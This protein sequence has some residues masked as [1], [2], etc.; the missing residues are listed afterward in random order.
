MITVSEVNPLHAVYLPVNCGPEVLEI[1]N[2][3]LPKPAG[4]EVLVSLRLAAINC[5]DLLTREDW[6][7]LQ[8]N[9]DVASLLPTPNFYLHNLDTGINLSIH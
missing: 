9:Y 8:C 6:S 4:G 3:E 2:L 7:G 1:G 5:A